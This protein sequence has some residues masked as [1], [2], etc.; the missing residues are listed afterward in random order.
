MALPCHIASC[1]LTVVSPTWRRCLLSRHGGSQ[2]GTPTAVH[3]SLGEESSAAAAATGGMASEV[4][5]RH[6]RLPK[7]LKALELALPHC[8][9]LGLDV[10]KIYDLL[11]VSQMHAEKAFETSS[12][13]C[14]L[15]HSFYKDLNSD[16]MKSNVLATKDNRRDRRDGLDAIKEAL[17]DFRDWCIVR[18]SCC[19]STRKEALTRSLYA[20][21]SGFTTDTLFSGDLVSKLINAGEKVFKNFNVKVVESEQVN[22]S[23]QRREDQPAPGAA[24]SSNAGRKP[25]NLVEALAAEQAQRDDGSHNVPWPCDLPFPQHLACRAVGPAVTGLKLQP[26]PGVWDSSVFFTPPELSVGQSGTRFPPYSAV[27]GTA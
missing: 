25:K 20:M 27:S 6:P 26:P 10:A 3:V 13:A 8:E 4:P 5:D 2:I 9:V 1:D 12:E 17:P 11:A 22:Q 16:D 7:G 18:A 15:V 19:G 21:I 23:E 14:I 24:S